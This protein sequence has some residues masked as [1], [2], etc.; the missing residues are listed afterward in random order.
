MEKK[1]LADEEALAHLKVK[2]DSLER[3][4]QR[5]ASQEISRTPAV[6]AGLTED[7]LEVLE[8]ELD[9]ANKEIARLQTLLE[10]SPARKAMEKA[11]DMKIEILE[12][13]KE[14]FAGEEQGSTDDSVVSN[15]S[16][17]IDVIAKQHHLALISPL[18]AEIGRLQCELDSAN[19]NQQLEDEIAR[20]SRK[21]QRYMRRFSRMR[22]QK[23]T[24]KVYL[25]KLDESSVDISRDNLPTEPPT[26]PTRTSEALRADV[27]SLNAHLDSLK[28]QWEEEKKQLLGEKAVLQDAATRL[29]VQVKTANDE[30][31]KAT[32]T[33]KRTCRARELEHPKQTIS[34][35]EAAL[36]LERAQL[37]S[38]SAEQDHMAREKV[39]TQL[40]RTE[41][42][43]HF[44]VISARFPERRVAE[45]VETI[46]Q[47]R[48]ERSL[49]AV[50]HK[51]LQ[52]RY[53]EMTELLEIEDLRHALEHQSTS[54]K[55]RSKRRTRSSLK[56]ND[57]AKTVAIL[58]NDL[59]RVRR[60]AEAFGKDLE[61]LR[62]ENERSGG[63]LKE[64]V[65]KGERTRKQGAAPVRLLNEQL[66]KQR[67]KMGGRRKSRGGMD[68]KQ[69]SAIKLQ[70]N[71]E[72]KGLMLQ[73]RYLKAKFVKDACF[74]DWLAYR[75]VPSSL[76][77]VYAT[78]IFASIARVGFSVAKSPPAT[79]KAP[80]L[81]SVAMVVFLSRV[82]NYPSDPFTEGH[83]GDLW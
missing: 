39:M 35:L 70:H 76:F 20:L 27:M 26:P 23:C 32:E 22:C 63:R 81:K 68:G 37:R 79:K 71:K 65:V 28:K 47:L 52:R 44:V 64:E 17:H 40:K 21:E 55:A 56:N 8:N 74:R 53:S 31:R 38:F 78:V 1:M 72:C 34:E 83:T 18:V 9:V 25:R 75:Y 50:D 59:K 5:L 77:V 13:G 73:T 19:E 69:V 30:A 3:E 51:N 42:A 24:I 46:T 12:R 33:S 58:E 45:N 62:G 36:S 15:L 48:Q 66:E 49:L 6:E 10:Q 61:I 4:K 80:K 54:S 82:N 67:E 14:E 43:R 57:V 60:D 41:S 29:N 16:L 2:V 7:D 11:E